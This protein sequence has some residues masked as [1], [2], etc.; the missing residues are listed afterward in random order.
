MKDKKFAGIIALIFMIG[1]TAFAIWG[2]DFF[3]NLNSDEVVAMDVNGFEGIEEASKTVSGEDVTGYVISASAKGY[4]G[5]VK[6]TITFENDGVTIKEFE[7]TEQKETDG[8]G[9]KIAEPEFATSLQGVVAPVQLAGQDGEGTVIDGIA[10]ATFSSTA[11]VDGIN[12]AIA[13]IAENK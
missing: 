8:L 9:A 12:N 4:N 3:A 1:L 6:M 5:D 10:H 7:V 2:S 13:F 11:V